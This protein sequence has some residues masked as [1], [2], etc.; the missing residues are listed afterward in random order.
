MRPGGYWDHHSPIPSREP[1]AIPLSPM[2]DPVCV[3]VGVCVCVCVCVG[4]GGWS[5]YMHV[6]TFIYRAG[7]I[8][9]EEGPGTR[10]R[11]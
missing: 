11:R 5:I 1:T 7:R 4:G 6:H 9:I 2:P 8:H 3:G 10:L